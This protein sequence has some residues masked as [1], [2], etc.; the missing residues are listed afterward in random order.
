MRAERPVY[1]FEPDDFYVLTKH[2]DVF[3]ALR[4]PAVFSSAQGILRR[5]AGSEIM[6]ELLK[7]TIASSDPPLHTKLRR[8][9]GRGLVPRAINDMEPFI[10]KLVVALIDRLEPGVAVD[11]VHDFAEDIPTSVLGEL[12]GIPE[13]DHK[14]I[15]GLVDKTVMEFATNGEAVTE[16][17]VELMMYLLQFV[18]NSLDNP[19]DD[20]ISRITAPD[21]DGERLQVDEILKFV[22][23]LIAAGAET[24]RALL[25]RGMYDL[26]RFPEE[27]AR[28]L[29][30]RGLLPTAIEEMFRFG[31]P[32][33]SLARVTT[34]PVTIR[35]VEIPADKLVILMLTAA[36][37]D[38]EV[39]G[40]DADRFRIDR[41]PN[42]HL[43]LGSGIHYCLGAALA[44]LE[45][46]V[47]FEELLDR[48]S[49]WEFPQP[50][51]P[52]PAFE[53]FNSF[54]EMPIIFGSPIAQPRS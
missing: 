9:V 21:E 19:S 8:K 38:E 43:G 3:D 4:N 41:D 7:G 52:Y 17:V 51:T 1:W 34:E 28:L 18:Q 10:R 35:G 24:T 16:G 14:P 54:A 26:A 49:D 37:F 6:N 33:G 44:R 48:F 22:A 40:P 25:C 36:N 30:D 13:Q 45:V 31:N 5:S 46:R 47:F 42:P 2:A 11:F 32:A 12:C 39:F 23:M 50:P 27:R 53:F 29:A 15:I 20:L